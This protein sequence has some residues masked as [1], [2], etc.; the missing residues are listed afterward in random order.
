MAWFGKSARALSASGVAY[1]MKGQF[2]LAI[3][4]FNEAIRLN[5][6]YADAFYNRGN[7]YAEQREYDRAIASYDEAIRL[8]PKDADFF[9]SLGATGFIYATYSCELNR[10]VFVVG[11]SGNPA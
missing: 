8:N 7:A 5:P 9:G 2:D 10:T 11:A 6:E 1:A 4:D 3:V